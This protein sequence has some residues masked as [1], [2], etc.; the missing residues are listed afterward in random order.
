MQVS[1]RENCP[2]C[3]K[4][5]PRGLGEVSR[6]KMSDTPLSYYIRNS[7]FF[8]KCTSSIGGITNRVRYK[9][10]KSQALVDALATL[11]LLWEMKILSCMLRYF[12]IPV[13]FSYTE[14]SNDSHR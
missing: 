1:G 12:H 8:T 7:A 10:L 11:L 2:R 14:R 13:K 3:P 4:K 9:Q 6:G 5:S